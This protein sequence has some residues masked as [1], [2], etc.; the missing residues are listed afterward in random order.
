MNL[1]FSTV[2]LGMLLAALDQTIVSTA[3]P[4]IVGDLGGAGHMSWVVTAY[5][6]AE[7]VATVLAG[8]FGDLFG[9]K[10]VFQV[11]VIVFIVG[12]FFC[13]LATDMHTLIAARAVQGIGGGALTVTATALIGEAIPLRERGRYQ[14]ALGAVFG[15][16]T[17]IGPLLGGLFTDHLSWRWAFYVNVPI[18]IVVVVMAA[19]TIPGLRGTSRPRIDY[20]G[21]LFVGLG[22]TGLTLATAWGGTEYPWGSTTIVGLFV[23]SVVALAIFVLVELRAEEPILPMRLFRNP[24]FAMASVLSFIVGFAMLGSITFLPTF[25]QYVGGASA[26]VS[27][28]RTL[29]MVL[30]LLLTAVASGNVVGK[31]GRYREFPIVGSALM[32]LGLYLLSRMDQFTSIWLESLYMFVLGAGIGLIMQILTLIVQNTA[33]FRDLG[34]ATSGVT[35][36]RTLGSSFGASVMGTIYANQL[37]DKLPAA[38]LS[39]R[40][41]PSSV[42]TPQGVQALPDAARAPIVTA[43]AE[44]LHHM[45]LFAI[46]VAIVGFVLALFLPQ[47]KLRGTAAETA[48]APGG[49]FAMPEGSDSDTQVETVIGRI[50]RNEAGQA[51]EQILARSGSALDAAGA[52][53]LMQ[54]HVLGA[55]YGSAVAQSDIERRIGIPPGVLTS[56]FDGLA[57][58]GYLRRAGGR[59]SLTDAGIDQAQAISNAWRDWLLDRLSDWLPAHPAS[60][61]DSQRVDAALER[62]VNRVIREEQ[63]DRAALEPAGSHAK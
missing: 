57:A 47:V 14:G 60:M 21:V 8:K 56:F 63:D 10:R 54:V 43:Y 7:T 32:A 9:R 18:A 19:S 50:L 22:A 40:V 28:V 24:V 59:L 1:V 62:I 23:G 39:A 31:T 33:D 36:F 52:W 55:V 12:S 17:V 4:T 25:L 30:G 16:T 34:S 48:R 20:L 58:A 46:P 11:A 37:D 51:G 26:T 15:V 53:G 44:A 38:L 35:F 6:L 41:P 27:G 13:G 49:G 3:L 61:E 29:P 2:M 5:M 45:F 42:A